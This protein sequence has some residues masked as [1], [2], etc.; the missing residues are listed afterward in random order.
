MTSMMRVGL[1]ACNLEPDSSLRLSVPFEAEQIS[2]ISLEL[3][4]DADAVWSRPA[5]CA[6]LEAICLSGVGSFCCQANQRYYVGAQVTD[7]MHMHIAVCYTRILYTRSIYVQS[8][9]HP[10]IST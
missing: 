7:S 8:E 9:R 5:V 2:V 3:D 4:I 6:I 10:R 1:P